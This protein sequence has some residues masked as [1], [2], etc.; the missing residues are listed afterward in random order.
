MRLGAIP[1][2][3]DSGVAYHRLLIPLRKMTEKDKTIRPVIKFSNFMDNIGDGE[4][5]ELDDMSNLCDVIIV[6]RRYGD[7][8]ARM[9]KAWKSRGVKVV[10]EIDDCYEKIPV[11]NI[12]PRYRAMCSRETTK[13]V[14]QMLN[15]CDMITVSTPELGAWVK[16]FT[17]NKVVWLKNTLDLSMWPIV[18]KEPSDEVMIGYS[19]ASQHLLDLE[20]LGGSL[21]QMAERHRDAVSF[22][23]M[24]YISKDMWNIEKAYDSG[25]YF[26]AGVPFLEYPET[27]ANLQYDICLAPAADNFFNSCKSELKYL[28]YSAMGLPTIASDIAPYRRAIGS[29][30]V[31]SEKCRGIL[32]RNK[33]RQFLSSMEV[34][35]A[36]PELRQ[37]IGANARRYVEEK[38]NI[39]LYADYWISTYNSLMGEK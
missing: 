18:K 25:V 30:G 17:N 14:G 9:V 13:A 15:L 5:E 20:V 23:F 32:V 29:T 31:T 6:Q 19:G 10:Y 27:L 8:W 38:Y 39:E 24:G 3:K 12:D 22:G 11:V 26:K 4:L 36:N 28:E 7:R 34:L 1:L 2:G 35:W 33:P 37:I 21:H 16:K